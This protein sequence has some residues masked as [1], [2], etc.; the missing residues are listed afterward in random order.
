MA[1]IAGLLLGLFIVV[2]PAT[3]LAAK[4]DRA[5]LNQSLRFGIETAVALDWDNSAHSDV[6]TRRAC[7][8]TIL[9]YYPTWTGDEL[10]S[11]NNSGLSPPGTSASY[12]ADTWISQKGTGNASSP[13][14]VDPTTQTSIDLQINSLSFVCRPFVKPVP[15]NSCGL[16]GKKWTQTADGWITGVGIPDADLDTSIHG[17]GTRNYASSTSESCFQVLK[18]WQHVRIDDMTVLSGGGTV[19]GVS[20]GDKLKITAD[21]K[22]RYWLAPPLPFTYTYS[23]L[24]PGETRSVTLQMHYKEQDSYIDGN[25]ACLHNGTTKVYDTN[26]GETSWGNCDSKP[27]KLTFLLVGKGIPNPPNTVTC[28]A[29]SITGDKA[30]GHAQS[31]TG[32]TGSFSDSWPAG[33]ATVSLN[34]TRSNGTSVYSNGALGYV[35]NGKDLSMNSVSFTPVAADTYTAK[36][37]V[38]AAGVTAASCVTTA[39]VGTKPYFEGDGGDVSAGNAD[40]DSL[41]GGGTADVITWN[42]NSELGSP[43]YDGG[44]TNLAVI[45]TGSIN[46]VVT[47]RGNASLPALSFASDQSS[48]YGGR[49]VSMATKPSYQANI[50]S[51]GAT[52]LVGNTFT[53]SQLNTNGVYTSDHDITVN[54]TVG[55]GKTVTLIVASGKN[56]FVGDV[57]YAAYTLSTMPRFTAYASPD[58]TDVGGNIVV[59]GGVSLLHG[60]YITEGTFYTCG[61]DAATGYDFSDPVTAANAAAIGA[62]NSKLTIYGTISASKVLLSRTVGSY[63]TPAAGG[64]EIFKY[65]PEVWLGAPTSEKAFD[66]Y[67]SLPP[68]L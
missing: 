53:I 39:A 26:G 65:G 6:Y 47:G 9:Q 59:S 62:C 48:D 64:A 10:Y 27:Q 15:N 54:G 57:K 49:F 42:A 44:N 40:G 23:P 37:T 43:A 58:D 34:I 11:H 3:T 2:V 4:K 63:V 18:A 21:S 13:I 36:Y 38:S 67:V 41:L 28:R 52:A 56:I 22:S 20:A 24:A 68:I 14:S 16:T 25:T 32:A 17:S 1:L 5:T 51:T 31:L 33:G 45:A 55:A 7:K 61:A 35:Q 12:R 8:D 50:K 29:G 60:N 46:G 30:V 66:N 19:S